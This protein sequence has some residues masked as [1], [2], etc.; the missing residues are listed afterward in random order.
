MARSMAR[1][2]FC[3][4]GLEPLQVIGNSFKKK[5]KRVKTLCTS[6]KETV[7]IA[8]SLASASLASSGAV[9]LSLWNICS[10]AKDRTASCD[11]ET[12][13]VKDLVR[14]DGMRS[15][16]ILRKMN[17]ISWSGLRDPYVHLSFAIEAGRLDT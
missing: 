17:S 9:R 7:D 15:C 13:S 1:R 11:A 14:S 16:S 2:Y 8:R 12:S 3:E 10:A 4:A 5:W 6:R